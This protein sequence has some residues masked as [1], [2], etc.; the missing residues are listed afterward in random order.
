MN[1]A[2]AAMLRQILIVTCVFLAG[3]FG[4]WVVGF[5]YG[6]PLV[7]AM[8]CIAA[9]ACVRRGGE[10]IAALGLVRAPLLPTLLRAIGCLLLGY[11]G[12]GV[13]FLA[14]T[15][16]FDWAPPQFD[17]L[18]P[19]AG[20]LPWLMLLLAIAWTSAAF[21]EELLFRGFLLGRLRVLFG[22]GR[23]AG[24]AAAAVQAV[25]FGTMHGYQGRTG[26]LVTG[27]V[28]FAYG[29]SCLRLRALWPLVLAHGLMD[30]IALSLLYAGFL[31]PS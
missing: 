15:R 3:W 6:G 4:L 31:P 30:T 21:G 16:W 22:G 5:R 13:G 19:V 12:S 9:V 8:S 27:L 17:A 2:R 28:G 7:I 29:L 14:A 26:M 23:A 25:A 11:V 1:P 18:G 24:I 20:N 10:P